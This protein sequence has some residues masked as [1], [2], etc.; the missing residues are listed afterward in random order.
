MSRFKKICLACHTTLIFFMV[1]QDPH[2]AHRAPE[3]PGLSAAL[4]GGVAAHG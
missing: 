4:L 1:V 2:A 3:R